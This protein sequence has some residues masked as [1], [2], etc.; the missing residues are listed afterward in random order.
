MAADEADAA[1]LIV[2][3]PGRGLASRLTF[4]Y[5]QHPQIDEA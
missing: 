4:S 2:L 3:D 5:R 1:L